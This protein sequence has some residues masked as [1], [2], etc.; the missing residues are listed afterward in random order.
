MINEN[1]SFVTI[2]SIR[3]NDSQIEYTTDIV[4]VEVSL[5]IIANETEVATLLVSPRDINELVC[6]Y[7]FT[8]GFID[9]STGMCNYLLDKQKWIAYVDLPHISDMSIKQKR[10]SD[11]LSANP[12]LSNDVKVDKERIFRL[13]QKI[14]KGSDLFNKTGAVHTS[15]LSGNDTD[16]CS[17]DIARHNSVDK[18]IGRALLEKKDLSSF[19]LVRTGRISSEIVYK[20]RRSGISVAICRGAPTDQ[21]VQLCKEMGITLV[22]FARNRTFNIYANPERII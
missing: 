4:A 18:V 8:A 22:G 19:I 1:N 10:H 21:A 13:I 9:D 16:F 7:L 20:V 15:I 14:Q 3:V 5:T 12:K 17:D 2:D 6:G 11:E